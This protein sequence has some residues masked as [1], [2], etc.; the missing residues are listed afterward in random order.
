MNLWRVGFFFARNSFVLALVSL[1]LQ[2]PHV[3]VTRK[4]RGY[5][6][7]YSNVAKVRHNFLGSS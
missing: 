5:L 3:G 6:S 2:L 7:S 4:K 1:A